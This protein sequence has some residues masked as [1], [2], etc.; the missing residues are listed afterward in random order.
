MVVLWHQIDSYVDYLYR[1]LYEVMSLEA[2]LLT[3]IM[4][5]VMII[6]INAECYDYRAHFVWFLQ[7]A[8]FE[9]Y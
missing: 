9:Y 7:P 2:Q 6:V 8:V 3:I 1:T 4:S 5:A